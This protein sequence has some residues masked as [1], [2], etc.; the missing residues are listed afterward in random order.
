MFGVVSETTKE[1]NQSW[2]SIDEFHRQ[3]SL[4]PADR[5]RGVPANAF[6]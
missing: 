3:I 1:Q 5:A 2:A 6:P 4:A